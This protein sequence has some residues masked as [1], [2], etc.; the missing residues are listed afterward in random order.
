MVGKTAVFVGRRIDVFVL[1]SGKLPWTWVK[2]HRGGS[3]VQEFQVDGETVQ[4]FQTRST[5]FLRLRSGQALRSSR[6][7]G[8]RTWPKFFVV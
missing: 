6:Q 2:P 4:S 1:V 3:R 5:A 8:V 7:L